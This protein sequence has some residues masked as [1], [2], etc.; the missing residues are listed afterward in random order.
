MS[1]R[2]TTAVVAG[3]CAAFVVLVLLPGFYLATQVAASTAALK[4]VGEVRRHPA[5]LQNGLESVRDRLSARGYLQTPLN[6]VRSAVHSL[7]ES[8]SAMSRAAPAG[9]FES[10]ND[11]SALSDGELAA[12]ISVLSARWSRDRAV[13]EPVVKFDAV[14]YQDSESSG[15]QLNAAGTALSRNVGDAVHTARAVVPVLDRELGGIGAVLQARNLT[16]ASSLRYVMVAGLTL[17]ALMA[18]LMFA[19]LAARRR[20]EEL[21]LAARRQTQDILRT[22]KEGLFLLDENLTIGGAHSAALCRLFQRQDIAGLSFEQLLQDIVPERTLATAMKFVKILWA[23][24]TK[25][26]L[27]KSINP[28]GEVEVHL[29]LAGGG[30]DTRYLEFDFH[31]VRTDGKITHVLVSVSDISSRVALACELRDAQEKSQAQL[32]TLVGIL[33]VDPEQLASFLDDSDAAMKMINAVLREPAREEAA[34]RRKLDTIF[35]QVHAVKGEAAGLGL[36]S[37]ESRAHSFEEDLRGLREKPGLS[38]SEFLPLVLKLDDLFTH[39]Q[40]IRDLVGRLSQLRVSV[41]E[42]EAPLL[43]EGTDVVGPG[44]AVVGVEATITQV[45]QRIATEMGKDVHIACV[46]LGALPAAYRRTV[47]DIAVQAVRNSMVHG[48]EPAQ[49]RIKAGKDPRGTIRVEVQ[50]LGTSGYKLTLEDDGRGLST[51]RIKQ[52]AV[53]KKFVTQDQADAMDSRQVLALLFRAGFS[54]IDAATKDAGRGVGMSLVAD[55][56][57]QAGGKLGVATQQGKFTRFTVMLP[58]TQAAARTNEVA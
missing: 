11:T 43:G 55:L 3:I 46:G 19:S 34:F 1:T 4:F 5:S 24:R 21:V 35:R 32:D 45:A 10:P 8:L 20:Q 12:R 27:V 51:D 53:Q 28:L 7:D 39:L 30:R 33:H 25:E 15:T 22:V 57:H 56:V 37:I 23:E 58:A 42:P 29:E 44:S 14:P 48:I 40:A 41:D 2:A 16:A 36:S 54:T 6:Q 49:A 50:D 31:R 18:F 38:G 47:K 9:L 26:N 13:F 17:A 52:V